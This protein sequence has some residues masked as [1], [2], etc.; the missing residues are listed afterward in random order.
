VRERRETR[1]ESHATEKRDGIGLAIP[2]SP[3]KTT[4]TPSSRCRQQA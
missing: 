3:V 2:L 1:R 4:T